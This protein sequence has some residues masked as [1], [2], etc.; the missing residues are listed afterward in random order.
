MTPNFISNCIVKSDIGIIKDPLFLDVYMNNH[1]AIVENF[2]YFT[3]IK[4]QWEILSL[5]ERIYIAESNGD[6]NYLRNIYHSGDNYS[7]EF[8][9]INCQKKKY[10]DWSDYLKS[11]LD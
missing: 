7:Y 8:S 6:I 11:Y 2:E 1:K 9:K 3:S 10:K 5:F 4:I